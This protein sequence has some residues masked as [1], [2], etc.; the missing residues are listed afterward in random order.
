MFF[1]VIGDLA[2]LKCLVKLLP[3][4]FKKRSKSKDTCNADTETFVIQTSK[5]CLHISAKDK[6]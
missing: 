4:N 6:A 5:V 1:F 2:V 3:S